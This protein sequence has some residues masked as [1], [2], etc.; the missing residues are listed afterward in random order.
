M[1]V[2]GAI[3]CFLTSVQGHV[4]LKKKL[5][6]SNGTSLDTMSCASEET[7]LIFEPDVL[8]EI[9]SRNSRHAPKI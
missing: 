2:G 9:I 4:Q 1:G 6:L 5:D 8:K 3:L 7:K